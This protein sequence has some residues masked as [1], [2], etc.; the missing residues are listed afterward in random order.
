MRISDW[1]SDV[2]SS[3]LCIFVLAG[4]ARLGG[5]EDAIEARKRCEA[6]VER[7]R[8]Q[9]VGRPA[10]VRQQPPGFYDAIVVQERAEMVEAQ[11]VVHQL[12]N[13]PFRGEIG[14]ASCRERVCQ[15]G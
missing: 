9:L 7:D 4:R 1:S 10:R 12:T 15:Y 14:R 5:A 3:D 11:F 2:C 13:S 8:D 6:A